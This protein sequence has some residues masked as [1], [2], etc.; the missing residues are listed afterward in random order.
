MKPMADS[1]QTTRV[2]FWRWLIRFIGVIVPRRFRTRWRREW[3]AELEY[4]EELLSRW[5]RLN[6]RN[7]LELLWRS[8]GAF[9]D[10]LWLQKLRWEDEMIQDLRFGVRMLLK[11]KGFTAV[12]ALTL[13]L[14]IGAN[15]A[16]FSVVYGVLLRPLPYSEPEQLVVVRQTGSRSGSSQ[17]PTGQRKGRPTPF[18]P[19]NWMDFRAQ[20]TVFADIGASAGTNFV[21]TDNEPDRV[22]G[23]SVSAGFFEALRVTPLAGRL[24]VTADETFGAP[25][26]VILGAGI[27]KRRYG[28]NPEILGL[29]VMVNAK[30]HLVIGIVPEG[31]CFPDDSELWV[32]LRFQPAEMNE[33]Q[34]F[35][36]DVIARLKPGVSME[37]AQKEMEAI[38]ARLGELYPQTNGSYSVG[39]ISL[40][41]KTVGDVGK[42]LLLLLGAA[43]FVLLIACANVAN[44][45]LARGS[46]RE[47]EMSLRAALG[48]SRLRLLR[49][50]MT[51]NALLCLLGGSLGVVMANSA[52]SALRLMLPVALPRKDAILL[53]GRVLLFAAA[54]AVVAAIIFGVAP[55]LQ[56]VRLDLHDSLKESAG[57]SPGRPQRRLLH[58]FVVAEVALSLVLLA[59]AGLMLRT[60]F[61]L[62]TTNPGFDASNV[63]TADITLPRARYGQPQQRAAFC[64][65]TIQRLQTLPGVQSVSVT[66]E[67]PL[68]G[69][70]RAQ[71][72]KIE[73]RAESAQGLSGSAN[74]RGI[75]PDYFKTLRMSLLRGRGVVE[76]DGAAAPGVVVINESMARAFWQN[77]DPIGKRMS[78][79]RSGEPEW[80]E[81]VGIVGDIRHRGLHIPPEPEMYVPYAQQPWQS[82]RLAIRTTG[83]PMRLSSAMRQAVWSM[84]REQP[85][86]RVQTLEKIV[87]ASHSETTFY[88]TLLASFAGLALAMASI[89]IYG[90]LSYAVE[91]RTREI[92]VRIALGAQRKDVL[93]LVVSQG[94]K[95]ALVGL[96]L[97]IAAAWAVTRFIETLLYGVKP[98]DPAVFAGVSLLLLLVAGLAS[99]LPARR[100]TKLDP[101][102]VLR[103]E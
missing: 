39:V 101:M 32:P 41:E 45:L 83:D 68:A 19:P 94:L 3:E 62:I 23:A 12:A 17:A 29:A 49:Q 98:T 63:L 100:A 34:S 58:T 87:A 33:R 44:L 52:V 74:F 35:Y 48:A 96:A 71:G 42:L 81:V 86:T 73:G 20:Q 43:A 77:E 61:G 11:H 99:W 78:I 67:L 56:A 47:R 37:Q 13:A 50:L 89:G 92:G 85:V 27:W 1:T 84:D 18:S 16:I 21:L 75:S 103:H 24:F 46:A 91:R 54:T 40:H 22:S 14:G 5:D 95:L 65:Q 10:A 90:V 9:W 57:S 31:M 26:V 36:L 66:N 88:A 80:R 53:D 93:A 15:T 70:V 30:P 4:R 6:W 64:D 25:E 2:S 38:A 8:L 76:R 82:F 28:G 69:G 55:L 79:A 59:G 97:G 51:E 60:L 7:K 102:T 72:F